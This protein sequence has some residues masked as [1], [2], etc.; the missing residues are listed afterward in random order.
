MLRRLQG[1]GGLEIRPLQE[2]PTNVRP[3]EDHGREENQ[4]ADDPDQI[5]DGVIGME[6]DPIRRRL[7][8]P[9]VA[10]GTLLD[11]DPVRV[12]GAHLV[13][14]DDM[15]EHQT[16]DQERHQ[17]VKGEEPVQGGIGD[18]IIAP[19]PYRQVF[20]DAGNRR[21]QIDDDLGPPIGHLPPGQEITEKGRS[22]HRQIKEHADDPQQFPRLAVRAVEQGAEHMQINENE[23]G[24]SAGGMQVTQEP[25][26]I[27]IAHDIRDR[28]EGI[29]RRWLIVHGQPKPGD[30]LQHQHQD[31]QGTHVVPEIKI[32]RRII[33]G[34]VFLPDLREGEALVDPTEESGT[35]CTHQTAPPSSPIRMTVS[36]I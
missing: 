3:E 4:E 23:K 25:A 22:H 14:G 15:D 17:E 13:Q 12:V 2:Q 28:G 9:S 27:H 29:I 33:F 26:P 7:I 24:G 18:H 16:R 5:L 10:F 1:V 31:R 34:Q 30:D 8:V 36:E 20:T 35:L 21:E 32:L 11:L 19:D 6:R